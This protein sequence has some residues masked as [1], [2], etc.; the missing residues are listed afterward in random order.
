MK[1]CNTCGTEKYS[2]DFH[3]RK[4]SIDGLA[5]R[6]KLCQKDYDKKRALAPHRV[7]ARAEYAKTDSGIAA[8]NRAKKRY[9][10]NNKEKVAEINRNYVKNNPKKR[11][12][13]KIV[14]KMVRMNESSIQP[15][16]VCGSINVVAHHDDYDNPRA[17]RWLCAKHHKQ[18][19]KENGEGA[20]AH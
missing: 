5:A 19:H 13:H 10:E 16:E 12:A 20:N 8:A 18:W 15:C 1:L 3:K 7:K 17:V 14:E 11:S 2:D 9:Y 6:C 4:A